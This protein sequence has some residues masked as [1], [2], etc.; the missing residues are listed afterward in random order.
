MY[1]R[2]QEAIELP[3]VG[4]TQSC[5]YPVEF[6]QAMPAGD[7]S[8]AIDGDTNGHWFGGSVAHTCTDPGDKWLEI[9]LDPD[10]NYIISKIRIHN[11]VNCCQSRLLN[12]YVQILNAENDV[13]ASKKITDVGDTPAN[14]DA[15]DVAFEDVTG[16]KSVRLFKNIKPYN[17]EIII[18]VA[19][20]RVFGVS[21]TNSPTKTPTNSPTKSPT[22][23][24]TKTPTNSPTK[25]PTNSPTKTPTNSPTKS[26]T[27]SP[28]PA[29]AAP[30]SSWALEFDS[31]SSD[32]DKDSVSEVTINYKIG[33]GRTYQ[34]DILKKG[35]EEN[36][37]GA[38]DT[39]ANSN[40]ID[41]NTL[42]LCVRVG[43]TSNGSGELKVIKKLETNVDIELKFDANFETVADAQFGQ[44]SLES[45]GDEAE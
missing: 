36:I 44:I 34:V 3:L 9:D 1:R 45:Q 2:M 41:G 40:I 42:E 10:Y 17:E 28:T 11:R 32:F 29:A 22:N 16:G 12:T 21:S 14:P 19:E 43:L 24:P 35:C 38:K 39:I 37:T 25:S 20:V 30:I 18:N 8:K 33:A 5:S 26:P 15:V 27:N 23:S 13:I 4:A 7:A 31:L 6:G